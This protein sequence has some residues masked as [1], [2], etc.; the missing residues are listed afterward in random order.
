MVVGDTYQAGDRAHDEEDRN[1]S[2]PRIGQWLKLEVGLVAEKHPGHCDGAARGEQRRDRDPRVKPPHKLLEHEYRTGD[3]CAEC[4]GKASARAG[5]QECLDIILVTAEGGRKK[6]TNARPHLDG[7]SLS[8]ESEPGAH[9]QNAAKEFHWDQNQR[10]RRLLVTQHRLNVRD[11]AALGSRREFADEPSGQSGGDG[12][13]ADD[14]RE[15]S[16]PLPCA[17]SISNRE[18]VP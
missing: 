11:A 3:R 7:G 12:R 2:E 9:R 16:N 13:N 14:E 1:R 17:H 5:G 15:A 4:R 8:A 6:M 10:R 18:N